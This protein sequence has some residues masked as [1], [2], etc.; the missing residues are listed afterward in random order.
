MAS[1]AQ[2]FPRYMGLRM[3]QGLVVAMNKNTKRD[4]DNPLLYLSLQ[5]GTRVE[6]DRRFDS[7]SIDFPDDGVDSETTSY[8]GRAKTIR[9]LKRIVGWLE[10]I[11]PN[12]RYRKSR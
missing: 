12:L 2:V 1:P 9:E 7:V 11:P 6:Y 3:A 4:A 10:R 8:L 5:S